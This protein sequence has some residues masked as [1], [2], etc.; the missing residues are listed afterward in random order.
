MDKGSSL[1]PCVLYRDASAAIAWLGEV[2]GLREQLRVP[3]EDGGIH[4]AQLLHGHGMLML[5]TL[6]DGGYAGNL[7]DPRQVGGNT[8]GIYL[9]LED[10]DGAYARVQR[11]GGEILIP[12]KDEEYGGRGFTCRDLEGQ[13]WSVGSY[14]PWSG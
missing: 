7:R 10:V 5:G 6:R 12:I 13:L 1:I 3:G 8:Q 9:V 2:F 4:H 14:D 11:A